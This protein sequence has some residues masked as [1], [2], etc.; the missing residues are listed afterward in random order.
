[1]NSLRELSAV[2]RQAL[3]ASQLSQEALSAQA[4]IT[5]R[6]LR[7]LLDGEH[8]FKLTTL[9]A[10]ADKLGL[11]LLLLPRGAAAGLD[12]GT[13]PAPMV[14]SLIEAGQAQLRARRERPE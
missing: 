2:V 12:A 10:V 4:G 1:M 14:T 13:T 5:R 6:T 8:D 9:F 7:L 11:Q 3:A